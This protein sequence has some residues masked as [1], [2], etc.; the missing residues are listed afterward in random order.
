MTA[1]DLACWRSGRRSGERLV[2]LELLHRCKR[3]SPFVHLVATSPA[4]RSPSATYLRDALIPVY[5]E[6]GGVDHRDGASGHARPYG[7]AL[8]QADRPPPVKRCPRVRL[9][10]GGQLDLNLTKLGDH[11]R[12]EAQRVRGDRC[13]DDARHRGGND[14]A[15]GGHAVGGGTARRCKDQAVRADRCY[16]QER[17]QDDRKR[18][19]GRGRKERGS[20]AA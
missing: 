4:A 15:P 18:S 6:R 11:D 8:E 16:L 19:Q 5:V 20:G 9:A 12:A 2:P 10:G 3:T 13:Q 1:K 14:G 7:A 17:V